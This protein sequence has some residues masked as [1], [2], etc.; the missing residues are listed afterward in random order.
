MFVA[1]IASKQISQY[2]NVPK[3]TMTKRVGIRCCRS[4]MLPSTFPDDRK[5][6]LKMMTKK[7]VYSIAYK[8]Q[9]QKGIQE[10]KSK[11]V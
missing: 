7:I 11:M 10:L 1:L 6:G 8:E 2:D 3:L 9:I 4:Q 5:S